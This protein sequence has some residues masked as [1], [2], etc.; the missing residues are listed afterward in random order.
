M[1]KNKIYSICAGVLII[2]Q[3]VKLLI[4]NNMELMQEIK[5]IPNFFSLLYVEN[6]GAAFGIFYGATIPLIVISL[7]V[8]FFLTKYID[9]TKNISKLSGI[10]LGMVMGGIVG[11][12]I[13]RILYRIVI[14]YLQFMIG[15]YNF[16]IF[17][18]A[19]AAIVV[20]TGLLII[21]IF[22]KKESE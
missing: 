14:D 13:D 16:A 10:A 8:F 19:D 15:N 12:L 9:K 4:Q 1:K 18:I 5:I 22:L 7:G 2:D 20:G 3:L 11:N 6:Q 21:D 17:N